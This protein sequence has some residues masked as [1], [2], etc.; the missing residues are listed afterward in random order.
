MPEIHRRNI[1]SLWQPALMFY[2]GFAAYSAQQ[3]HTVLLE[4]HHGFTENQIGTTLM[5]AAATQFATP[6]LILGLGKKISP[7]DRLL[8]AAY[9]LF[10]LCLQILPRLESSRSVALCYILLTLATNAVFPMQITAILTASRHLGDE[11]FLALRSVGTLGFASFCLLASLLTQYID[12]PAM[13]N[14]FSA[15]GVVA[16]LLSLTS[17]PMIPPQEPD[18]PVRNALQMLGQRQVLVWLG[19]LALGNLSMFAGTSVLGNF[20]RH[21]LHGTNAMVSFSWTLST[22]AEIPLIWLSMILLRH[23]SLRTMILIGLGAAALRMGLTWIVKDYHWFVAIQLLHGLFYGAA[24]SGFNLFLRRRFGTAHLYSLQLFAALAH[25]AL[26]SSLGG[27]LAGSVWHYLG[28]RNLYGVC[29]ALLLGA[30]LLLAL[31]GGEKSQKR[32]V[33]G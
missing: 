9:L 13:Y 11:W 15:A 16:F 32:T 1:R 14:L 19:A 31:G 7:P 26:A 5:L 22:F 8:Q 23:F 25:G 21:E 4:F 29:A 30:F 18:T 33:N 3:F 2:F 28:L 20:I 27:R 17:R 10:A 6:F 24:L 12:V